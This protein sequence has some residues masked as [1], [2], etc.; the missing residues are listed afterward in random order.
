MSELYRELYGDWSADSAVALSNAKDQ[1]AECLWIKRVEKNFGVSSRPA[2]RKAADLSKRAYSEVAG[3][4]HKGQSIPTIEQSLRR[5]AQ[6]NGISEA[7]Q[8][9]ID[10][11]S[12]TR[13]ELLD[14]IRRR[15][16]SIHAADK[17]CQ[18]SQNGSFLETLKR[19]FLKLSAVE[20]TQF[21]E[22]ISTEPVFI[23]NS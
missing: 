12:R 23:P 14:E 10:R 13:P 9:K 2:R 18:N 15:K 11:I 1:R 22:W 5:R 19:R 7:T 20:Q 6:M 8:K 21:K 4:V 17:L 16:I 3:F